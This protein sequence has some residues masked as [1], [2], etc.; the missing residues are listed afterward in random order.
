MVKLEKSSEANPRISLAI[1]PREANA[2]AGDGQSLRTRKS[3]SASLDAERLP[4]GPGNATERTGCTPQKVK[5][6]L[7]GRWKGLSKT[8][9]W[10]CKTTEEEEEEDPTPEDPRAAK[11]K[12]PAP[13]PSFLVSFDL[14]PPRG[15][16][17]V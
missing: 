15:C 6:E 12:V 8:R 3:D 17:Y 13:F 11:W 1:T 4:E 2:E 5:G 10:T 14:E 9:G 16:S 7:C